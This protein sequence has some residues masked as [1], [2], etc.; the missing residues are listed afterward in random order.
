MKPTFLHQNRPLITGM[1]LKNNPDSIR[2]AVKNS[3][4]DGADCLGIQLECLKREYKTEEHFRRIFAA[5]SGHPIYITNYRGAENSGRSDEE[6]AEELITAMSCGATL[7]DVP[8]SAFDPESGMGI[9]L[10]L[11]RKTDA[12]D[13]QMQLI[14]RLHRMG[15]E[16]MMSSHI[17]KFT[18][19]ETVLEVAFEQ[20]R[21]GAD[22]VKLVT[23]ANSD[24]EQM[25]NLRITTLL[26]KELDVPFLFLSGGAYSKI[27][28][29]IGAQLGCVTYLAVHEHDER[30]VPTQ[31]TIRAAKAV[32]DNFDY[33][34]DIPC[35]S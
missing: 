2:Y 13:R 14:D 33:V 23:A 4:Y 3:L 6:L 11:S 27:H 9:G 15:K 31:P 17:L 29:M 1:I 34:P 25:E 7:A 30:A 24:E 22:I 18:P 21:R 5:C 35:L 8:G 12:V 26:K 32:R 10:E 16:V 20:K 28:R 19:A